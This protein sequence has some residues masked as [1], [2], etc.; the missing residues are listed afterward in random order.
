MDNTCTCVSVLG[1][2]VKCEVWAFYREC[3]KSYATRG[4]ECKSARVVCSLRWVE[5]ILLLK[6]LLLL[7]AVSLRKNQHAV[8]VAVETIVLVDGLVVHLTHERVTH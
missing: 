4:Q 2:L 3:H 8:T 5:K 7:M 1:D 6:I